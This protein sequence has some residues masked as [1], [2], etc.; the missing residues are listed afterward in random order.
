MALYTIY[1]IIIGEHFQPRTWTKICS[2]HFQPKDFYNFWSGY[3]TLREDAVPSIFPF[4]PAEQAKCRTTHN[5]NKEQIVTEDASTSELELTEA[6]TSEVV[7]PCATCQ[8]K[9]S[10]LE[11]T[12]AALQEQVKQLDK[13]CNESRAE[14]TELK[15]KTDVMSTEMIKYQSENSSYKFCFATF[16]D[17]EK[18]VQFYTGLPSAKVFYDLLDFVSPDR[19]RSNLIYHATAQSWRSTHPCDSEPGSAAWRESATVGPGRPGILSQVD[20]FFLTLVRLRL[21][22]KEKDL[23][24]R[25]RISPSSVSR[26][27]ISWINFCYLRL[28][29]LPIWPDRATIKSTMPAVF[30]EQ[31]PNTTAI[32]DATEIKVSIPSSLLLQSQTYS[33][34]KSAN[35]FKALV[36]I[37]PA[38]HIIFVSSLYTGCISDVQLVERSGFL[39]LLQRGDEVMADRGFTIEDLLL[40]LGVGLNIPPFLGSRSQLDAGEVADTQQIAS[41]RIHI[42]RAIR[43][44]KEFDILS[45]VMPASLAG[46]ANQIWSVCSLLINFQNPIIS[47]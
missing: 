34:Y 47:C 1:V 46:S 38:G 36:A 16:E 23:A 19:K 13:V 10:E 28:G 5:S 33:S 8:H 11:Q 39:G 9:I 30:K 35:T 17:C 20:E 4:K 29:S 2:L 26:I 3:R 21:G 27:F 6:D 42:E 25:F 31:Y 40:P 41:L 24:D 14:N 45:G 7:G 43:R 37:S 32:L 12:I 15:R 22:L 44:I 18:D